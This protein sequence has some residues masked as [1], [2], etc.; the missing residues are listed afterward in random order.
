MISQENGLMV[1]TLVSETD[2]ALQEEAKAL[3]K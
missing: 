1:T 2:I 3:R